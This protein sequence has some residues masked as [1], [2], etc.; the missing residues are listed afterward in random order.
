MVLNSDRDD[1]QRFFSDTERKLVPNPKV[2]KRIVGL[3]RVAG[4]LSIPKNILSQGDTNFALLPDAAAVLFRID[5]ALMF[6]KEPELAAQLG[7]SA[8]EAGGFMR[9]ES[10]GVRAWFEPVQRVQRGTF[11]V[12]EILRFKI[13]GGIFAAGLT[14]E[15]AARSL[16]LV[17][18]SERTDSE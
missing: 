6:K 14:R 2:R 17:D 1:F 15:T 16:V 12:S 8:Q 18:L 3:K 10:G 9:S 4:G 13:E 7:L 5:L 11:A